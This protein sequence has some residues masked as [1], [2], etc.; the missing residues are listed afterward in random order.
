MHIEHNSPLGCLLPPRWHERGETFCPTGS[1]QTQT[2]TVPV[3]HS[4]GHRSSM[5][6]SKS[7]AGVLSHWTRS[8]SRQVSV[9]LGARDCLR[10]AHSR[11]LKA[12]WS[13]LHSTN[14]AVDT[15]R[16]VAL[17]PP[18]CHS[19]ELYP[20][21]RRHN[22]GSDWHIYCLTE[23]NFVKSENNLETNTQ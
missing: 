11:A 7:S 23:F 22:I 14:A 12:V 4:R 21:R 6:R 5:C 18:S 9:P 20:Q 2:E 1:L 17:I 15:C 16:D 3:N 10:G 13:Q 19:R 8:H